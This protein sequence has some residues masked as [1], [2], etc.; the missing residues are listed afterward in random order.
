MGISAWADLA[1]SQNNLRNP[2]LL[3]MFLC[4]V[5][6]PTGPQD[7]SLFSAGDVG[8]SHKITRENASQFCSP[9]RHP[10]LAHVIFSTNHTEV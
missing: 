7:F 9:G 3:E 10:Y 5:L 6:T 1:F 4:E 2:G 8:V